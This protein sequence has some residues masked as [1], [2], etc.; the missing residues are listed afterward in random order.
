MSGLSAATAGPPS[1]A[2][3]HSGRLICSPRRVMLEATAHPRI[4]PVVRFNDM[5]QHSLPYARYGMLRATSAASETFWWSGVPSG[6]MMVRLAAAVRLAMKYACPQLPAGSQ[7]RSN[8]AA[9]RR[10]SRLQPP[11]MAYM[12]PVLGCHQAPA[13]CRYLRRLTARPLCTGGRRPAPGTTCWCSC[14]RRRRQSTVSAPGP[15][16]PVCVSSPP[17]GGRPARPR[18]GPS[19]CGRRAAPWSGWGLRLRR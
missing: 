2:I 12:W 4:A 11:S 13:R 19:G 7:A 3:P 16:I 15:P 14:R 5:T 1:P 8:T 6:L 17:P 10:Y 9:S 18:P